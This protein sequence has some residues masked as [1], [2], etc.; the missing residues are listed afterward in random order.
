MNQKKLSVKAFTI[1]NSVL[2]TAGVFLLT[3]FFAWSG[4]LS[5]QAQVNLSPDKGHLSEA[6]LAIWNDPAFERQFIESYIAETEIEPSVTLDEREEME[7][8]L[9]LIQ[10]DKMD[11]AAKRLQRELDRNK[12]ASA[13]FDFT[14]ANIYFQQEKLDQAGQVYQ[15]AVEK[16]PKFRRAWKNLG[17]IYIRQGKF[18]L[19]IPALTKVVEYGGHDAVT[20]GLL[21][22]AYASMENS[23]SAESS[24]R[25]AILLDS[26]TLDWKMG[27]AQSFF[28][29]E[30]YAEAVA[31]C[32]QLITGQ[33][34]KAE[35][36]MLQAN[37]YIGLGQ[38]MKA[39]ENFVFVENLGKAT[40]DSLNLL[41]DIYVNEKLYE[42]AVDAYIRAM[43][44]APARAPARAIRSAKILAARAA[45]EQTQKLIERIKAMHGDR[46][47]TQEQTDLLKLQVRINVAIGSGAQEA[48]L[49]EEIVELDPL[50]GEALILL[51]HH[52]K[53]K[54]D[55][56]K[57]IFYYERAAK[58]ERYEAGAK[59]Q[60]AKLLVNEG[61][62]AEALPLL[63][64]A[65]QLKP[66]EN[67]Q[68]F[69]EQ[70]ERV[71]KNR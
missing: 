69:L 38:P 59:V 50:D 24:Y 26:Q 41:G 11:E 35:L 36:W 34:G 20:Y 42:M 51:G 16:F 52:S 4:S 9:E 39:A 43:G 61:K 47:D 32:N 49:L 18:E 60:H 15:A 8:I 12:A 31:V 67:V 53:R 5:A 64:Q 23:I 57:A 6:A 45:Y 7:E 25:M 37:A 58:I 30:R 48:H 17:L 62:Y 68:E 55:I 40:Y 27:L 10:E 22:F 21:G 33:P 71:A 70:V 1:F 14:L 54:G 3:I 44:K 19:A 65:Q 13:V 46:L 63:R 66:R 28:K 56:A 2:L 29:Q